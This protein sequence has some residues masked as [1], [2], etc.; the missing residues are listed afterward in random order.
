M[1]KKMATFWKL[2]F[3]TPG[4]NKEAELQR[5]KGIG[6]EEILKI[7]GEHKYSSMNRDTAQAIHNLI[8]GGRDE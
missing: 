8:Q 4:E 1:I 5:I 6:V 2:R 3:T 7:I